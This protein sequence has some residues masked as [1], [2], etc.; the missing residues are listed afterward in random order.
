[1]KSIDN[2]NI[3]RQLLSVFSVVFKTHFGEEELR[4]LK[5]KIYP[6]WDSLTQMILV[7]EIEAKFGFKFDFSDLMTFDSYVKG[8]EIVSKHLSL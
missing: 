8:V 6:Q 5:F 3:E 4:D 2:K 7:Q 1:M